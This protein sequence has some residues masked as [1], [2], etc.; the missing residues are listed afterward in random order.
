MIGLVRVLGRG[1]A[2]P[3][4]SHCRSIDV[5]CQDVPTPSCWHAMAMV[6]KEPIKAQNSINKYKAARVFGPSDA[7]S[8]YL[9]TPNDPETTPNTPITT[10]HR[11]AHLS[12]RDRARSRKPIF[13]LPGGPWACRAGFGESGGRS[14]VGSRVLF[15][16]VDGA[17]ACRPSRSPLLRFGA[18]SM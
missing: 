13:Q 11:R 10:A 5:C 2:S 6:K 14:R 17:M 9:V 8:A 1:W 16:S 15:E 12:F 4:R 3:G 18:L 7:S